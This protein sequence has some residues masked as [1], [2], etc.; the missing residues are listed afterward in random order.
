MDGDELWVEV[1]LDAEW[2]ILT[3][4]EVQDWVEGA[5]DATAYDDGAYDDGGYGGFV[6]L[7]Y[8]EYRRQN[9]AANNELQRRAAQ[10]VD[11]T[12]EWLGGEVVPSGDVPPYFIDWRLTKGLG[13]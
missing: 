10:G 12:D 3:G 7:D 8:E 11:T 1:A 5:L 13:T 9:E 6:A 4:H 2:L